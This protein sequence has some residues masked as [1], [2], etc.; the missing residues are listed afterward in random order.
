VE[1]GRQVLD[2]PAAGAEL[3]L[4]AAVHG[5][6]ALLAVVV[7]VEEPPDAAEARRLE[8]QGLRGE[9]ESVDVGDRVDGGVPGDA[10]AVRGEDGVRLV[11][12][13]GVLDPR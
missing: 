2:V 9:G 4:A 8:V 1:D 12:Q 6:S 10:V 11:V 13:V 7:G 3:P 5:H